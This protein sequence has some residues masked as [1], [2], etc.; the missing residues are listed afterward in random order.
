VATG[1]GRSA[2]GDGPGDVPRS[3]AAADGA[4]G[5]GAAPAAAAAG[6]G[7]RKRERGEVGGRNLP[8]AIAVGVVLATVLIGSVYWHPAAFTVVIAILLTVACVEA[9]RV[10]RPIGVQLEVP[11]LLVASA[12]MLLGAY[13][14]RHAGQAVGVAVLFIGGVLWQVSDPQRRE[15]VRT[16]AATVMFGLWL[17][18]LAS[19]GVLLIT[20]PEA[21]AAATIGV[22]GAAVVAD[23]GAYAF[24][25]AFG[26]RRIAPS[27][28][29]N[30]TWE[31][32]LG[33]LLVATVAGVIVL[34]LLSDRFSLLD[35]AI[36]ALVCGGAGFLGDLVESMFKRDLGVKDL[37]DLLPGHGGVLDRVDG[38]LFAL[39]VGFYTV[40]LLLRSA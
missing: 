6:G 25:V 8:V 28:S 36:L 5:A 24:G 23:I 32:F 33:G 30:K 39:P 11:V 27:I 31:G 17:G 40:E 7:E 12:V 9:S 2:P 4:S 15:V 18:F 3:E 1:E 13:Q 35:G 10:L 34:P 37:G 26:R 22:I 21:A 29:P 38:I 20:R 14:A 19:F 16:L